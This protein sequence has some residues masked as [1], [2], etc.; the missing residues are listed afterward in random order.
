MRNCALCVLLLVVGPAACAGTCLM[1]GPTPC[2]TAAGVVNSA[3]YQA[4]ELAPGAIGSIFGTGLSYTTRGILT[5]DVGA[6]IM[7]TELEG[8]GVH[9]L[10]GNIPA[11]IFYVSPKQI[12]FQVP[13][14]LM[15]ATVQ[16]QVVL[17]GN[18]GP[19]VPV[20]LRPAAPALYQL[21]PA[22][23]IATKPDGSLYTV[24]SPARAGDWVI[25]YATGLGGTL[26]PLNNLEIPH[27][28]AD[29]QQQGLQI[30][31][32][33]VP[34][35]RNLVAYAGVAPGFAGLYQINV[36]LPAQFPPN[37]QIQVVLAGNTSATGVILPATP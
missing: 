28:A 29:I 12:N 8:T 1:N 36:Q 25:L 15:P 9:V 33:T 2:Y 16:V 21:D 10:V 37:P 11:G 24:S 34:L 18:A 7:P 5:T 31:L 23:V 3:D 22:T 13:N 35:D 19:Q 6:G 20:T 4:G 30:L 32:N 27:T 17:D 14:I 26:P